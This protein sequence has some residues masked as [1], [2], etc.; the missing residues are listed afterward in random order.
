M[1]GFATLVV[2]GSGPF[3]ARS[4]ANDAASDD[5]RAVLRAMARVPQELCVSIAANT[6][7]CV[8]LVDGTMRELQSLLALPRCRVID[9]GGRTIHMP[10]VSRNGLDQT[11]SICTTAPSPL[12]LVD[13]APCRLPCSP[14]QPY[15]W[16]G[17]A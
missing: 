15:C 9:L 5:E 17:T 8:R 13:C 4:A 11:P 6:L 7:E 14:S 12:L 16:T 10:D 1:A 3:L 2:L